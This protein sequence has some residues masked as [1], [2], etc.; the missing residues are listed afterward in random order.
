[1]AFAGMFDGFDIGCSLVPCKQNTEGPPASSWESGM[2][3]GRLPRGKV[4]P[5]VNWKGLQSALFVQRGSAPALQTR[6]GQRAVS[7]EM[8]RGLLL[9]A[10]HEGT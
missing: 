6:Q 8:E 4:Q 3:V 1:M 10:S 9:P 5:G 2:S 7:A